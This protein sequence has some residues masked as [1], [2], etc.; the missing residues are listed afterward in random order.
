MNDFVF[1][2]NI[3]ATNNPRLFRSGIIFDHFAADTLVRSVID[4]CH[5]SNRPGYAAFIREKI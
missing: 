2:R 1:H 5:G 4:A 3:R